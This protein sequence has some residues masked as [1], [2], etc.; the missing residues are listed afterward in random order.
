MAKQTILLV[1]DEQDLA[2]VVALNFKKE[3]FELLTAKTA[4]DGLRLARKRRPALVISDIMLPGM[5]GLEMVRILRQESQVPVLFLTA[6]KDEVDRIL[7]FKLGAD[8]YL[9]KPFSM[10]EL[11]CRVRAILHRA[12]PRPAVARPNFLRVGGIEIDL[13]RREVRVNGRHRRVTPRELTVLTLLIEADG[14]VLSREDLLK[15]LWGVDEDADVSTRTVDQHI[16]RLRRS[17]LSERRR[18]VTVK[19]LGYKIETGPL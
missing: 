16:A 3:G 5:D 8:D 4:E 9:G 1:E 2:Y 14:K 12:N 17:L 19:G 10:R 6:R 13:D 7:G 15:R 18:I 11:V